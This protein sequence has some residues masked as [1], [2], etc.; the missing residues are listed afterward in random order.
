MSSVHPIPFDQ[1]FAEMDEEQCC[2]NKLQ[3]QNREIGE[4]TMTSVLKRLR[5]AIGRKPKSARQRSKEF[6]GGR[7]KNLRAQR[8][9][10]REFCVEI[11]QIV[12]SIESVQLGGSIVA[13]P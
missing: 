2:C 11:D 1:K 7:K 13:I 4:F 8:A 6:D 5:S 10:A 3:T 9:N 12:Q